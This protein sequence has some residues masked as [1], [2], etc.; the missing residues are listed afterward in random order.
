MSDD[1]RR[2]KCLPKHNIMKFRHEVQQYG[3]VLTKEVGEEK[4]LIDEKDHAL[5]VCADANGYVD[6]L[7]CENSDCE[8]MPSHVQ[9]VL[10][11]KYWC[12][13]EKSFYL[14]T[15]I[16]KPLKHLEDCMFAVRTNIKC[17]QCT[18]MV[19]YEDGIL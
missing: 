14:G 10:K 12:G 1:M 18:F 2:G 4:H 17:I 15:R 5:K 16:E 13:N 6:C 9:E 11:K 19:E 3:P 8:V 7:V